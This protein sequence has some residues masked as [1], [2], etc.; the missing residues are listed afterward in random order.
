M[1]DLFGSPLHLFCTPSLTHLVTY[2]VFPKIVFTL[3]TSSLSVL[4][5]LKI[6]NTLLFDVF[7]IIT[8]VYRIG[9]ASMTPQN[10]NYSGLNREVWWT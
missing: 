8:I 4:E 3:I 10:P 9:F 6:I 5:S 1:V 7:K 2:W